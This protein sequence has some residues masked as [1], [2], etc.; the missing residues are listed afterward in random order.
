MHQITIIES[1]NEPSIQASSQLSL[2]GSYPQ[3]SQSLQLHLPRTQQS[4][5]HEDLKLIEP[6]ISP[7]IATE[8]RY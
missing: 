4:I 3:S 1:I 6:L 8:L 2:I 7:V 5:G